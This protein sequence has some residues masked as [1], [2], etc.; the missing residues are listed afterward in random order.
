MHYLLALAAPEEQ[1][2]EALQRVAREETNPF[3][4]R[5][6]Q[7]L[8]A[9]RSARGDMDGAVVIARQ[10]AEL[11]PEDPTPWRVAHEICHHLWVIAPARKNDYLSA[12]A[13]LPVD[14]VI[15][16]APLSDLTPLANMSL[17]ELTIQAGTVTDLAPLR[18][19]PLRILHCWSNRI[20]ELSPLRDMPLV[21]L[22]VAYNRI[23]DLSPLAALP[24]QRLSIAHNRIRDLTPLA[25]MPLKM[26]RCQ[27]NLLR[28]LPPLHG[29]PL[30][31]LDCIR[32][33]ISDLTPVQHLPLT[34]LHCGA[35]RITSLAPLAH[36]AL[37]SLTCLHN[38]L[39]DLSALRNLPL[40]RLDCQHCRIETFTPLASLPLEHL[41]CGGNP[42]CDL[43]PLHGLPLRVCDIGAIPL[44]PTNLAVLRGL[45]LRHFCCALLD[46]SLLQLLENHPTVTMLNG[47]RLTHVLPLLT[48]LRDGVAGFPP[49]PA[50]G[51]E[52]GD[53]SAPFCRSGRRETGAGSTGRLLARGSGSVLPLAA[54]TAGVSGDRGTTKPV[55]ALPE[56]SHHPGAD[57][58]L[59]PGHTD[60]LSG[61]NDALVLGRALPM[62]LLAR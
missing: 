57:H 44:T 55:T 53:R 54:G 16:D 46:P 60:R 20:Q 30:H 2:D 18:R 45:P 24:L 52:H 58:L 59:S 4:L 41:A 43:T 49:P 47:H 34:E 7:Q 36:G 37:R 26:L 5:A 42:A 56:R 8:A 9:F 61:T 1:K 11:L 15:I 25:G 6:L 22:N 13:R 10:L 31:Y 3:R 48:A 17:A 27:N 32:N 51:R 35:N 50:R 33:R 19:M 39:V 40:S 38:P 12:L 23:S 29:A 28:E 21:D 62:A 14:S